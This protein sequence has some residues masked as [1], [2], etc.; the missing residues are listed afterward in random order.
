MY[1]VRD[2]PCDQVSAH[3][4]GA[5]EVQQGPGR[6]AQVTSESAVFSEGEFL[7]G[8]MMWDKSEQILESYQYS[9][10]L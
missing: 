2:S 5:H 1:P 7:G 3:A 9:S 6:G 8:V 4:G 10:T